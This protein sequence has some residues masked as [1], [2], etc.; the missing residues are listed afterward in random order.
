MPRLSA[1]RAQ[2][3]CPRRAHYLNNQRKIRI[4]ACFGENQSNFERIL[5]KSY[6]RIITIEIS[7]ANHGKLFQT[8]VLNLLFANNFFACSFFTLIVLT[9]TVASGAS[10]ILF[11]EEHYWLIPAFILFNVVV[12]WFLIKELVLKSFLFSFGQ[13]FITNRELRILNE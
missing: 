10:L 6:S 3:T 9:I 11:F 7:V 8:T 4:R 1:W 13:S 5:N 12:S 2:F